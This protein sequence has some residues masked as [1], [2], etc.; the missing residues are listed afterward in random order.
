MSYLVRLK[1][2]LKM[3]ALMQMSKKRNHNLKTIFCFFYA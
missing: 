2:Q 3:K 1:K